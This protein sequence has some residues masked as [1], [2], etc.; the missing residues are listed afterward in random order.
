MAQ[1]TDD[2][3]AFSGPLLPVDDLERIIR[4]RIAPVAEI[5][6]ATLAQARGR[7]LARDVEAP[8]DLPIIPQWTVT[9]CGTRIC[10]R[11]PTPR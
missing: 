6:T 9:P 4:E 5:E 10:I 7:A 1:L 2:C 8:I 3:F 11:D